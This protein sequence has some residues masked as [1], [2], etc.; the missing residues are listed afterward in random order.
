MIS[1]VTVTA[2]QH[3]FLM[4]NWNFL[5]SN[6]CVRIVVPLIAGIIF[7]HYVPV[8]VNVG[9]A[10]FSVV[11]PISILLYKRNRTYGKQ[12]IT[13][14]VLN[15]MLMIVGVLLLSVMGSKVGVAGL[16]NQKICYEA[17]VVSTPT[18]GEKACK[19]DLQVDAANVL[20]K[21]Q[22]FDMRVM[23][24]IERDSLAEQ[25][26][27]GQL[28]EFISHIDTLDSPKNPFGFDYSQYLELNGIQGSI[29]LSSGDWRISEVRVRGIKQHALNMR[30]RLIALLS[31]AGL[32]GN[33]LGLAST[34]VLGYKNHIDAE[35]KQAYMCAG[36]MHVLAVSGMHVGIVCM[37]LEFLLALLGANHYK[38]LKQVIIVALLWAYAFLT[39]LSP[40]VMRAT[41]MFSCVAVGRI[42][43]RSISIYNSLAFSA[44]CLLMYDPSML[45]RAGFQL[46]YAAVIG[47]VSLQPL[48]VK[49]LP[50]SDKNR[51][52]YYLW[53]LT[54]VSIAAQVAT[55][56]FCLYYF[57][58]TPTYFILSNIV[59]SPGAVVMMIVTVL[60][61]LTSQVT[62][63]SAL[64]SKLAYWVAHT[65]N[66]LIM[67]IANLPYST[68]NNPSITTAQALM[69]GL[70]MLMIVLWLVTK[71]GRFA[72]VMLVAVNLYAIPFCISVL[73][74]IDTRAVCVYYVPK[75]SMIQ[76]VNGECSN[77][78]SRSSQP[79]SRLTTMMNYANQFW[80]ARTSVDVGQQA[81]PDVD[82]IMYDR[83]FFVFDTISGLLVD[84]Q[85]K[86]FRADSALQL[87]YLIVS[88]EPLLRARQIPKQLSFRHVIIDASV[89]PWIAR[90][91]ER[92]FGHDNVHNVRKQ[93]A[94]ICQF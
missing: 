46:S 17:V 16:S 29:F 32:Q 31:G 26:L 9:I 63:L 74:G 44:I 64:T 8:P 45:F 70:A 57:D 19:V 90:E 42:F 84:A 71:N 34:L 76:F 93:G 78:I 85:T 82:G 28:I 49:W 10:A 6:P 56:P 86:P 35:L 59:V 62:L 20:G 75:A 87:D 79:N 25:L 73:K 11:L 2:N 61:L 15:I 54:A 39:G 13:G 51:I 68:L 7:C 30:Q 47:I 66:Y 3:S 33:E 55:F 53:Q 37:M 14:A 38:R 60:L 48:I 41:V 1:I 4:N 69:V 21:W 83:S 52:I 23:A 50:I 92:K 36:A 81:Q 77:W 5:S 94:Y 80:S 24:T 65:M 12:W 88:G 43:D 89:R 72:V 18:I 27:A 58:Y 67:S 40:S 91:W 22:N